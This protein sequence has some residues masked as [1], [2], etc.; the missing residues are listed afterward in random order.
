MK[1]LVILMGNSRG[2]EVAWQS[3]YD[4][5]LT[6]LNADLALVLGKGEKENSL[7]K[8]AKYIKLFDE[9]SD[10]GDCIDMIARKE[11]LDQDTLD[12]WRSWLLQ[13]DKDGL[14]GGVSKNGENILGSGAIGFCMRYFVKEF[15]LEHSLTDQYDRFIITRTDH[16]YLSDHPVLDD[17]FE[18]IPTGEDYGG[19]CDRHLIVRKKNVVKALD[20]LIW[21]L[22]LKR[23][24]PGNPEF[25][26]LNYF[27][28]IGL[29]IKRFDR[30]FFLVK[31]KDD[32]TRW[33]VCETYIDQLGLYV[34]YNR[35]Y[36]LS[37]KNHYHFLHPA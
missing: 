5:V 15:I 18:W 6:P 3:L 24:L 4:R 19:I 27:R 23:T 35:E 12:N 7:Y 9:F 34:K 8:R 31:T 22:K 14:W 29:N 10:W 17:K 13:N 33:G 25:I 21:C 30:T 28:V 16:Y 26:E 36:T 1:T 32:M 37:L 2:S 20:V 11:C